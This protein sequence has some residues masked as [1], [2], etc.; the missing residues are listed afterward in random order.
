[1]HFNNLPSEVLLEILY[2]LLHRTDRYNLATTNKRCLAIATRRSPKGSVLRNKIN[3]LETRCMTTMTIASD[4]YDPKLISHV[5]AY[6]TKLNK[7]V[8]NLQKV[9]FKFAA[10]FMTINRPCT[11]LIP[12]ATEN[13]LALAVEEAGNTNIVL[14]LKEESLEDMKTPEEVE[15]RISVL[16]NIEKA[17]YIA[18][19]G[20][21]IFRKDNLNSLLLSNVRKFFEPN[22]YKIAN[23]V[24]KMPVTTTEESNEAASTAA[25]F[26]ESVSIV[27]N[28]WFFV[29]S[30][31]MFIHKKSLDDCADKS[32]VGFQ[33]TPV[34]FIRR[35]TRMGNDFFELTLR[36]ANVELLFTSGYFGHVNSSH[37]NAFFGSSVRT[38]PKEIAESY[39]TAF[40][41][42]IFVNESLVSLVRMPRILNQYAKQHASNDWMFISK[43]HH[44][45]GLSPV[46][47]LYYKSS[48][49]AQETASLLL[50]ALVEK[51]VDK[52]AF[53][54]ANAQL[55]STPQVKQT[56]AKKL[57][58]SYISKAKANPD[59]LLSPPDQI[60]LKKDMLLLYESILAAAIRR[61]NIA[62]AKS[63]TT[64]EE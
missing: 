29:T 26:L 3:M 48:N 51:N 37:C 17:K 11:F 8:F 57:L 41:S 20:N 6:A 27:E 16:K 22:Q 40:S 44:D 35:K 52:E 21:R 50:K 60:K 61:D 1:M 63:N 45:Q 9:K 53:K 19:T 28:N 2:R 58:R 42:S 39:K 12:A 36:F 5:I 32:A 23:D 54:A 14:E 62:L 13:A 38:L 33:K 10:L 34:L 56:A 55:K 4:S 7:I 64:S 59:F 25:R 18:R 31:C 43:R 47:P 46:H 49:K 30:F 24:Y 15:R